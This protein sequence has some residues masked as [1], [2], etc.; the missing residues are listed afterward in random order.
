MSKYRWDDF[1]WDD[2]YGWKNGLFGSRG[3]KITPKAVNWVS[4][5]ILQKIREEYEK[6]REEEDELEIIEMIEEGDEEL[7]EALDMTVKELQE[8]FEKG[9]LEWLWDDL[10]EDMFVG[11]DDE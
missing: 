4:T 1:Y 11:G 3:K 2:G 9:G 6:V 8:A 7:A 5:N 10:Y